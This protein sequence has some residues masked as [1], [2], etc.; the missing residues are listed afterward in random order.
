M[1]WSFG[2]F[3]FN[4]NTRVLSGASGE[5][6][7]EPKVSSLLYYLCQHPQRNIS[8]DELFTE[9]WHGQLVTDNAITRVIALLRKALSDENKVKKFI[10]TV[11]KIGYR[12]IVTPIKM[13]AEQQEKLSVESTV[14]VAKKIEEDTLVLDVKRCREQQPSLFNKRFFQLSPILAAIMLC[15]YFFVLNSSFTE[16]NN[17]RVSPL[18]RLSSDQFDADM[19]NNSQQLIYSGYSENEQTLFLMEQPNGTPQ[20]ISLKSGGASN[21][22]WSLDDSRVVYVYRNKSTCQFHQ[23]DFINGQAQPPRNIYQCIKNSY[24][25]FAYSNDNQI[26]YFVERINEYAPYVAYQLNIATGE[27]RR[28]AQPNA[29]GRG[30]HHFDFSPISGR[31]LLLSD[32]TPGNTSFFELDLSSDSYNKLTTFE[33]FID[34]AIWAHQ[35]DHIV[36]QG[37]H[38]S[39]QLLKTDLS[40]KKSSVLVSDTRRINDVKR[41]NN[42]RDYLFSS[43][44]FNSD[45]EINQKTTTDFNSSVTDFLP[46]ISYDNQQLAFISKRSGYSKIWLKNLNSDELSSIEPPDQGR[47][48]YSVQWSFDNKIL[49]ANTSNGLLLFDVKSRQVNQ[50]ITPALPAYGVNWV[51]DTEFVYSQYQ[52]ERW[53]LFK[54]NL[55]SSTTTQLDQQWAFA[56]GNNKQQVL[57]N[58]E[59]D[60]FVNGSPAPAE[61]TCR[62]PNYRQ[63]S[64]MRIDGNN[65]YCLSRKNSSE[66]LRLESMTIVHKQAHKM[67]SMGYYDYAVSGD[68]QALSKTKSASSDIMRTNF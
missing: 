14:I 8:R 3:E 48:F 4:A 6:V 29:V 31:F 44:M 5:R 68:L 38:P 41:I 58:Q 33:Y 20:R 47:S 67:K 49:L 40:T 62:D 10:V 60:I 13:T 64:T 9:V 15:V 1:F 24:S 66:L 32:Q 42:H 2:E 27:K 53:R 30:N 17:P 61:L 37:P 46:A 22:R 39:Y 59:M 36:H 7:L 25:D 55:T 16:N 54:Y 35:A 18:T 45:I 56:L 50:T 23:V 34:N 43:Y 57:I 12:F 26:L 65:F 28:L 52:S 21:A 11:P 51:S 19:A 63:R